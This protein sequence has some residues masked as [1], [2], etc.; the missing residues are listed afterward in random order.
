M[1]NN[2]KYLRWLEEMWKCYNSI[3]HE[4]KRK[5]E[6]LEIFKALSELSKRRVEV[7]Y[8]LPW[9]SSW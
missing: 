6:I 8:S 7:P 9:E 3:S 2:E 4:E 5:E 1:E